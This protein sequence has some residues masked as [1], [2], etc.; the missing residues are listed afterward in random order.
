MWLFDFIWSQKID[1][2]RWDN[3]EP[4]LLI[5]EWG[6]K[7]DELKNNSSLIVDPGLASIFVHNWKIEAVQKE[8]WKWSL[9]TTNIPFISSL[10]NVFS[11]LETH[12]KASVFFVKTSE[13]TNQK[14][15]TPNDVTYTDPFYNFPVDLRLFWNFSFKIVDIENFWINYA[16]NMSEVS[17]SSIRWF[18]ADRLIWRIASA[19]A[20]AKVSYNEIDAKSYEISKTLF[21]D[22]QEEFA[23]IWLEVTD[24]RI[25]DA[26]FSPRTEELIAKIMDKRTDAMWINEMWNVNSGSLNKHLEVEKVWAMRDAAS[27]W[28]AASEGLWAGMWMAMWMN[29][30]N[31]FWG[32]N[33]HSQ[34]TT[35]EKSMEDKLLDAKS[36]FDKGLI[37]EDEYKAMKAKIISQ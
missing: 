11:W 1:V 13:I 26:S 37:D 34:A 24:F 36:M 21:A 23:K 22:L 12:D 28:W 8:P 33:Q 16:A 25:E 14:W 10:K 5:K 7:Y 15:G 3:P 2:I 9:E 30:A 6:H 20:N 32:Q 17:V 27:S 35:Q 4:D 29:M 31:N 19:L 18:I